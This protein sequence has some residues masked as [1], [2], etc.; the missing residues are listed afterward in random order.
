MKKLEDKRHSQ[1]PPPGENGGG[2]RFA[3]STR[4]LLSLTSGSRKVKELK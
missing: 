1:K 4:V 3:I 2:T